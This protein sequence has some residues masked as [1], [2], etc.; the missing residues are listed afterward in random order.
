MRFL[1]VYPTSQHPHE[2]SFP[3]MNHQS[4]SCHPF[5]FSKSLVWNHRMP[6]NFNSCP[7]QLPGKTASITKDKPTYWSYEFSFI[8]TDCLFDMPES[9]SKQQYDSLMDMFLPNPIVSGHCT[10]HNWGFASV[11]LSSI[12]DICGLHRIN[13][14]E[15]TQ[16]ILPDSF[17]C[18]SP[19]AIF[20]HVRVKSWKM[21]CKYNKLLTLW[22]YRFLLQYDY[23]TTSCWLLFGV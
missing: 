18:F 5:Y 2:L 17:Q 9:N 6:P 16:A 10:P 11:S 3:Y 8:T 1:C 13:L 7:T 21:I 23:S 19:D 4:V 14:P 12:R 15:W 22:T 20:F